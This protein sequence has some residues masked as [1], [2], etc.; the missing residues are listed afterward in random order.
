MLVSANAVTHAAGGMSVAE[1]LKGWDRI[2]KPADAGGLGF[3]AQWD[4]SATQ[5]RG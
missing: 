3:D 2:T 4:G 1:D 5:F